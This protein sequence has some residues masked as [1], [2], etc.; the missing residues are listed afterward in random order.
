MRKQEVRLRELDV[1]K[2]VAHSAEVFRQ[3]Q[4]E[5]ERRKVCASG[6]DDKKKEEEKEEKDCPLL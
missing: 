5:L 1:E 3:S 2:L 6:T 4:T